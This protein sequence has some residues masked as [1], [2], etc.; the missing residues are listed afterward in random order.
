[1]N[2]TSVNLVEG[3]NVTASSFDS[4]GP[5]CRGGVCRPV[6]ISTAGGNVYDDNSFWQSMFDPGCSNQWIQSAWKSNSSIQEIL[7]A[8]GTLEAKSNA[9]ASLAQILLNP[10]TANAIDITGRIHCAAMNIS[11][12]GMLARLDTCRMDTPVDGINSIRFTWNL[13]DLRTVNASVF[14]GC[15]M[16][17]NEIVINSV[18]HTS[19]ETQSE[20]AKDLATPFAGMNTQIIGA[21]V[22]A[23]VLCTIGI[24]YAVYRAFGRFQPRDE[25]LVSDERRGSEDSRAS[26][27]SI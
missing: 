2:F 3:S 9:T 18:N 23:I 14:R 12:V 19:T 21:I 5:K 6:Q 13:T 4:I 1:M 16:N 8:Y 15:Q 10:N 25:K 22:V 20:E 7:I 24:C 26:A 17:V 27:E 11:N